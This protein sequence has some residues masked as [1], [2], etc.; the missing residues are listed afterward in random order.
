V[1]E[2]VGTGLAESMGLSGLGIRMIELV[3]VGIGNLELFRTVRLGA[4]E[5]SPRAFGSTY[6]RE[7]QFEPDD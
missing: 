3:P 5:E 1:R 6:A 7:A 4:L 2:R